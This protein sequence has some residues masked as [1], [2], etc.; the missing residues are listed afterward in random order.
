[1]ERT[2]RITRDDVLNVLE[3][4]RKGRGI[5]TPNL[6]KPKKAIAAELAGLQAVRRLARTSDA[7]VLVP[8]IHQLIVE[9]VERLADDT[10]RL[11]AATVLALDRQLLTDSTQ[12]DRTALTASTVGDRRV[13]LWDHW[14]I[15]HHELF[16]AT[17]TDRPTKRQLRR[18]IEKAALTTLAEALLG[19]PASGSLP[20]STTMG[21][22][23]QAAGKLIVVGGVAMDI[24]FRVHDFPPHETSTEADS[25][26]I[27]PGGKGFMQAVAASRLGLDTALLATIN[28]DEYQDAIFEQLDSAGVDTSL[29]RVVSAADH[30]DLEGANNWS[31]TSFTGIFELALG[32][33]RAVNFR[34]HAQL[35]SQDLRAAAERLAS[36]DALLVTFEVPSRIA[37]E[38]LT[39]VAGFASP[40]PSVIVTPGQPYAE[41]A[42][43]ARRALAHVDYLVGRRWEFER[44]F[45]NDHPPLPDESLYKHLLSQGVKN[46]CLMDDHGSSVYRDM[47][48]PIKGNPPKHLYT[49]PNS[50]ISRDAFCAAIAQRIIEDPTGIRDSDALTGAVQWATAAMAQAGSEFSKAVE[51]NDK[52]PALNSLPNRDDVSSRL[53]TVNRVHKSVAA[54]ASGE[55]SAPTS[56]D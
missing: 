19:A 52:L 25:F 5:P 41:G 34:G 9:C 42:K 4:L 7:A 22:H 44:I 3:R 56:P 43:L 28:D 10:Q 1:M 32:D 45:S 53:E 36:S 6:S 47:S 24:T 50:A 11:V 35:T 17:E 8:K 29:I 40:Q 15:L 2:D 33:S 13:A 55:Q 18:T 54:A 14:E 30:E 16:G 49:M 37:Q 27:T 23:P 51:A 26:K 20:A 12:I 48:E 21:S 46:V 31:G 39:M 38:L